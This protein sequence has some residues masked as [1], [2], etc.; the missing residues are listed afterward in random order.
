VSDRIDRIDFCPD[1]ARDERYRRKLVAELRR[2]MRP[3]QTVRKRRIKNLTRLRAEHAAL[4]SSWAASAELAAA[5][6]RLRRAQAVYDAARMRAIV[7]A[8]KYLGQRG[9]DVDSGWSAKRSLAPRAPT[10]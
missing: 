5:Q 2:Q 6:A 10:H 3:F 4:E 1:W 7:C 9:I 8:T